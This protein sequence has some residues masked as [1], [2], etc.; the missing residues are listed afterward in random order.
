M[1]LPR[2]QWLLQ[3]TGAVAALGLGG[4]HRATPTWDP[5]SGLPDHIEGQWLGPSMERAHAWRDGQLGGVSA[6][7]NAASSAQGDGPLKRVHTLVLGGGVAGL[8][9]ADHLQQAGLDDLVV[10]ELEDAAGGNS[11]SHRMQGLACPQGAHYLPVPGEQA[12]DVAQ[13]LSQQGLIHRHQGRWRGDERH[14]CHSPQ[15]RLFRPDAQPAQGHWPGHW[16]EGV[17]PFD[18]P[19]AATLSQV[20]RFE[21]EVRQ[22]AGA[23]HF[24]LPTVH[25]RWQGALTTLDQQTFA[26][27]LDS[28]GYTSPALRWVLD[29]ACRDDY[30]ASPQAV[31]AWAGL[32]YFASRHM[33]GSAVD[34]DHAPEGVLTWPEG[35]DHLVQRLVR[36]LG[37]RVQGGNVALRIQPLRH[38]VLVDVWSHRRQRVERWAAKQVVIALPLW[39]ARRL[40]QAVPEPLQ[41]VQG[42]LHPSPWLVTNLLL[43]GL[44]H[45]R[46]GAPLSWDNVT[47]TGQGVLDVAPPA[48]GYVNARHQE[49]TWPFGAGLWTHYW[50]LGGSGPDQTRAH[51]Q[52]LSTQPWQHWAV[53][54]LADL[55]RIH[56]DLPEQVQRMDLTRW[57]HGMITPVPGLRSH[58]GL[59]ALWQPQGR[60][61]FAHSD[62]SAYSVFEEAFTHGVRAA[63]QV[64]AVSAVPL[65]TA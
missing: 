49:M 14:L 44:P 26:Q 55:A 34:E 61:H 48:L 54:V 57:G 51:R 24:S 28:R 15:E 1:S 53:R 10:L 19:D 21:A 41:A 18:A 5:A 35:N 46:S 8:A 32:Q 17:L 65:R 52:A 3:A 12:T 31:S 6:T 42:L 4:C 64:L 22:L 63:R 37:D 13:W 59:Q 30:G 2:R 60:L 20:R 43:K 16:Q 58:P 36:P 23:L 33:M 50:A 11:R 27:W 7:D 56:P 62:L 39:V 9:A 47:Y 40:L 25:Q 45:P 29:Y 38:E